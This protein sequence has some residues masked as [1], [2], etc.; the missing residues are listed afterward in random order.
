M[1]LFKA[2]FLLFN[3][4]KNRILPLKISLNLVVHEPLD[5]F[6]NFNKPYYYCYKY[7][8]TYQNKITINQ[9]LLMAHISYLGFMGTMYPNLKSFI[10]HLITLI[11]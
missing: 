4:K 10:I 5:H 1:S 3:H 11:N 8:D 2:V 7:I 9:C 6:P